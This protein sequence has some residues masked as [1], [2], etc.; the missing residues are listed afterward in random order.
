MMPS[1]KRRCST[2]SQWCIRVLT[3]SPDLTSHTLTVE[4]LDPDMMMLLSYCR[5][6]TEPVCPV[7]IW[8]HS[9]E[10][11]SHIWNVEITF[12]W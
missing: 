3:I 9:N 8:V 12:P 2:A 5:H 11:R 6:N 4:S 10:F 1:Q 7:N